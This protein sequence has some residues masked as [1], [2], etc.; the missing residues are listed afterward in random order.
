MKSLRGTLLAALLAGVAAAILLG[1]AAT[2]RSARSEIDELFDYHLRQ[3]AL[4]LRDQRLADAL[5]PGGEDEGFDLVIQVWNAEGVRIY[6][7]RPFEVLPDQAQMGY[8]TVHTGHGAWRVFSMPLRDQVIQVAQPLSVRERLAFSAA[9]ALCCRSCCS[10]PLPRGSFGGSSA[11][12]LPPSNGWPAPCPSARPMR[13]NP[14][15]RRVCPA[16][17]CRSCVRSTACS[18]AL[19]RRWTT[20]AP[21]SPTRHTS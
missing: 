18:N 5:V 10:C 11:G 16:K 14:F 9:L 7:S 4:S 13:L 6:L 12:A 20:S 15:P 2:Y 3:V 8:A 1:G 19:A 21:L 17:G